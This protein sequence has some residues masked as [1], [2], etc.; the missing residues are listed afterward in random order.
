MSTTDITDL[1][2]LKIGN[3]PPQKTVT[4]ELMDAPPLDIPSEI[5][6]P[7]TFIDPPMPEPK[8]VELI[9]KE[10]ETR[11]ILSLYKTK[12]PEE[13]GVLACELDPLL[14]NSMDIAQ[15]ESLRDKCDKLL[16]AG[17]GCDSKRKSFN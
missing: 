8:S 12:F 4:A 14:M 15:L 3:R 1:S 2:R 6:G 16:G 5:T 11:I 17:S 7:N 13:L 10:Q 9:Q